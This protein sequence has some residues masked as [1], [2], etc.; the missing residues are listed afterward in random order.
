MAT[1]DKFSGVIENFYGKPL[2][3]KLAYDAE[4]VKYATPDEVRQANAWPKDSEI[5]D[6]VNARA[7]A[8]A[9]QNAM[10]A[11]VNAA[12]IVKPTLENDDQMKLKGMVKILVAAG[13]TEAEAK[14]IASN[15]L[16]IAWE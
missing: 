12:G 1:I 9:R 6:F 15:T 10:Q 13:K 14:D 7:K 8:T 11:A 5:V 16:G 4:S 2:T 3:E